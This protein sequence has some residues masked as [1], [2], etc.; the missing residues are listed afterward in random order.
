MYG[1]AVDLG[2]IGWW[3]GGGG[4]GGA[5]VVSRGTMKGGEEGQLHCLTTDI[6]ALNH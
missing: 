5:A 4:G 6:K 1:S 3:K 2:Q